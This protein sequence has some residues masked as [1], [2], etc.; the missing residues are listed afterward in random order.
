ML[1]WFPGVA[2]TEYL[3]SRRSLKEDLKTAWLSWKETFWFGAKDHERKADE[4]FAHV[5]TIV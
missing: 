5:V 4:P 3:V 2:F 1:P